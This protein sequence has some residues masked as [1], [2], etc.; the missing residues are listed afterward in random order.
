MKE[1]KYLGIWMD[2]QHADLIEFG[3]EPMTTTTIDCD[4]NHQEKEQT[5]ERSENL[6]HHKEQHEQADY[7]RKLGEVIRNYSEVVLFGPTEAKVELYN[8]LKDDHLF[9]NI[10]F[11]I[12]PADKMTDKQ[13]HALV[14]DYFTVC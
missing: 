14:R 1:A 6:M 13:Q 5:L 11:E 7:Y 9:A 2:H 3:A 10:K 12:I 4:F 8:T